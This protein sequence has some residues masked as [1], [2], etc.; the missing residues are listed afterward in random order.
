M[1]AERYIHNKLIAD[2]ISQQVE[3]DKMEEILKEHF[4]TEKSV[5][6]YMDEQITQKI[7]NDKAMKEIY[8]EHFV[9]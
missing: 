3:N 9:P 8:K 6:E 1:F 2:Q 5:E 4:T 7:E